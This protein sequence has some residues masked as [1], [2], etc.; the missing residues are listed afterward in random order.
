MNKDLFYTLMFIKHFLA[1]FV[2]QTPYMLGK[3]KKGTAWIMPLS[4]HCLVHAG[5]SAL[6]IAVFNPAMIWLAGLEFVA[7]FVIDRIKATYKLPEGQ[8]APEMKGKYLNKHY[9]ALGADQLAHAL[10]YIAIGSAMAF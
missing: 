2:W 3:G 10:T 1:D 8:W 4:A 6:I 9:V 5:L 7:H